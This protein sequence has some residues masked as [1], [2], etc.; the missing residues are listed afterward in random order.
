MTELIPFFGELG[1]HFKVHWSAKW[2]V[3]CCV[4]ENGK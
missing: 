4:D 2:I 1:L 3:E